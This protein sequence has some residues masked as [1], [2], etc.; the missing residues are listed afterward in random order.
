MSI[1]YYKII[2]YYVILYS[3]KSSGVTHRRGRKEVYKNRLLEQLWTAM[4][5]K[6]VTKKLDNG[7]VIF[8]HSKA[9]DEDI[10]H[11]LNESSKAL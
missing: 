3:W 2:L 5:E 9:S 6:I 7:R 11:C 1:V 8:D 4:D 10:L